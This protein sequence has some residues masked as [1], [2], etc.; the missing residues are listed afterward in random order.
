MA[1]NPYVNKVELAD[2]TTLIDISHDT[3]TADKM[4]SGVTAHD[5]TGAQISGRMF[6]VGDIWCTDMNV[7]PESVLGFGTWEL[8]R[9]VNFTWEEMANRTWGELAQDTWAHDK[10][11]PVIYAWIRTA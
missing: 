1:S 2:G 7:R 11:R 4:V 8:C 9:T 10:Y 5:M 3:V 6:K